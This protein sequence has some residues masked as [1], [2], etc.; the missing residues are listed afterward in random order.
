MAKIYTIVRIRVTTTD[1]KALEYA[2]SNALKG[3]TVSQQ[4][5][6]LNRRAR[7]ALKDYINDA[8]TQLLDGLPPNTYYEIAK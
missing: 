4:A 1:P 6:D 2:G 8:D 7:G 5:N 3:N